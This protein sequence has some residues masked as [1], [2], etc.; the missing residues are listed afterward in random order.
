MF[1]ANIDPHA[2]A[3]PDHLP[4][5]PVSAAQVFKITPWKAWGSVAYT[6]VA[7]AAGLY[8]ISV[9]PWYLL[10]FVYIY[11]SAATTGVR[12]PCISTAVSRLFQRC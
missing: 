3:C 4:R 7:V 6:L 11:M 1:R 5:P 9:A 12:V 2:C 8:A 10:P